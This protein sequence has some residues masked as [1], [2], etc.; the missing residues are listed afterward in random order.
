ML[1][2]M[3]KIIR[4]ETGDRYGAVRKAD[5]CSFAPTEPTFGERPPFATLPIQGV[6]GGHHGTRAPHDPGHESELAGATIKQ[7]PVVVDGN[8]ITS[9]GVGTAIAFALEIIR[10]LIDNQTSSKIS[11]AILYH[12]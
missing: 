1:A 6:N 8:I 10:Y 9:R 5:C 3:A 2:L 4:H 12:S 11:T 7:D